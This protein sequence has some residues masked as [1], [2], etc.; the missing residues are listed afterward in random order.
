MKLTFKK[1]FGFEFMPADAAFW[2]LELG[3][4]AY[5]FAVRATPVAISVGR[6][7]RTRQEQRAIDGF[8]TSGNRPFG[9]EIITFD[10][11]LETDDALP[12]GLLARASEYGAADE[13]VSKWV[14]TAFVAVQKFL[15]TYRDCKYLKHR[16]TDRWHRNETLVPEMT[17]HEFNTFLFYVLEVDAEHVFVGAFSEGRMT[18]SEDADFGARLQSALRDTVPPQRK[19][20]EVA[21]QRFIAEDYA[22]SIIYAALTIERALIGV[23][24]AQLKQRG[25]GTDSQIDKVLD[26][27]SKRLLC[28]VLLGA[29]GVGDAAI[30]DRLVCV[31]NGRNSIAHGKRSGAERDEARAALD[32]AEAFLTVVGVIPPAP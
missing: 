29:V 25:A 22:G 13:I 5:S 11:A 4:D 1:A 24:R 6:F 31:F 18:M 14:K 15:E 2:M 32:V 17:E 23:L 26:D 21:W 28:T 16:G 8:M 10:V 7:G 27:T 20:I 9:R 30:R 3:Q 12:E 19:L